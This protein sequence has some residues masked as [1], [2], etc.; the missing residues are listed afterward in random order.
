MTNNE[1]WEKIMKFEGSTFYTARGLPF[2]Y[3]LV[4]E[5]KIQPIRDGSPKWI[6]HR[7]MIE[8]A[9]TLLDG[10]KTVFNKKVIASS[11]VRGILTDPRISE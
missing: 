8:Y 7:S 11:Y 10:N 3:I 6:V 1:L 5:N 2:T 9:R 4:D